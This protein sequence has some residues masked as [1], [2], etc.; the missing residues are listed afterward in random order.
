MESAPAITNGDACA[1]LPAQGDGGLHRAV[2]E[3]RDDDT[4][5]FEASSV[6]EAVGNST[7]HAL[8]DVE[9]QIAWRPAPPDREDDARTGERDK[10]PLVL[11][12]DEEA[13]AVFLDVDDAVPLPYVDGP[14]AHDTGPLRDELLFGRLAEPKLTFNRKIERRIM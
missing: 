12:L 4:L 11:C 3:T 13:F 8:L 10:A 9:V 7:L 14:R 2:A 6:G 1:G 5:L